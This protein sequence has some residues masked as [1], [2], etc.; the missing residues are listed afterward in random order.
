MGRAAKDDLWPTHGDLIDGQV[1]W[2]WWCNPRHYAI[3]AKDPKGRTSP[4][5]KVSK[6]LCQ[7]KKSSSLVHHHFGRILVTV[8]FFRGLLY[9][10]STVSLIFDAFS[11]FPETPK[12]LKWSTLSCGS[13]R[14]IFSCGCLRNDA[15][16]A[17]E[18]RNFGF[19]KKSVPQIMLGSAV[20]FSIKE[21]VKC[22]FFSALVCHPLKMITIGT[23][24]GPT[25]M[26]HPC[27]G[28][29]PASLTSQQSERP[30]EKYGG[31]WFFLK[32]WG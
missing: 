21:P 2:K 28:A 22:Y 12:S 6:T 18:L 24:W 8:V 17:H 3:S 19:Q 16:A 4:L 10:T 32:K 27:S 11:K 5:N 15:W 20:F 1:V 9:I 7:I 26:S 30:V 14:C 29:S 13:S 23:L 25:S 31:S